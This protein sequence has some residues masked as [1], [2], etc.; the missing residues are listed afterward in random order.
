MVLIATIPG[1][2]TSF[3]ATLAVGGSSEFCVVAVRTM[4]SSLGACC[5]PQICPLPPPENISCVV[6]L[7]VLDCVLAV[8]WTNPAVYSDILVI[9]DGV[10]AQTLAGNAVMTMLTLT[11]GAALPD[12]CLV[13]VA[14]NGSM[15]AP[16]CCPSYALD[17]DMNGLPDACQPFV[18]CNG[19][20]AA[21]FCDIA[22][23]ISLDADLNGVPDECGM[24][25]RGDVN[26]DTIIGLVDVI[27]LLEVLFVA[28]VPPATCEAALDLNDDDQVQIVDAILVLTYLFGGGAA[29]PLPF[30]GC[31]PDPTV[32]PILTCAVSASGC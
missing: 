28:G 31:G 9:V 1:S 26:M 11:G 27:R 24:F 4:L 29:P 20:G 2:D 23:G 3:L 16:A 30:P 13:G 25:I 6:S 21:D 7:V 10:T 18:D 15:S 8:N 5:L 14:A 12:V 32:G 17:C 22:L 19:N